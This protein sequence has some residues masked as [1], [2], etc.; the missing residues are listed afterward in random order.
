V[1]RKLITPKEPVPPTSTEPLR[2]MV[3]DME[4]IW[5]LA[6]TRCEYGLKTAQALVE[7]ISSNQIQ[8]ILMKLRKELSE[9]SGLD[10]KLFP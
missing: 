6:E 5:L 8:F 3:L 4:A 10:R 9:K 7:R 1:K 2:Q